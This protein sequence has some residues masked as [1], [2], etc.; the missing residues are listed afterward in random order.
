M[1]NRVSKRQL[2]L[3]NLLRATSGTIR[4]EDAM[5]A[6]ELDRAH[7]SKLLAGWHNQGAIRRISRGL[8]VPISPSAHGQ[9]QVLEDPWILVPELYDPG[10]V[11]G[12]SALEHWELTEQLFR[13][14]C[15]LTNKRVSY[16][17]AKYQGI[18]FFSKY[19]PKNR[20]FGMKTLWRNG[21]KLH[22][23]DIHKTILDVI[24]DPYLGAGLQHTID[25]LSEFKRVQSNKDDLDRLLEYAGR[26]NNGAIFKKLGFLGEKLDFGQSFTNECATRLTTGYAYL[27]RN[28]KDKK[29][30]T[31]WRLW[32][33]SGM[34]S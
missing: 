9:T 34:M 2:R 33:P 29:L 5:K 13:T 16:G 30:V 3:A 22:I 15:V 12:W 26:M 27:D 10:Y 18:N 23:S 4:V 8:Y 7:A 24:D 1:K 11:G 20:L 21:A 25:C 19:V 17:E 6:L 14:I 28:A 31:K 32:I